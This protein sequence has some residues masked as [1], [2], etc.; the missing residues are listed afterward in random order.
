MAIFHC[1]IGTVSRR[2]GRS[3]VD[4]AAYALHAALKDERT[5]ITH[6]RIVHA[7]APYI[8]TLGTFSPEGTPLDPAYLWS[9]AE[10]A[11]KRKDA[12]TARTIEV[13]LPKELDKKTQDTL[14]ANFA[15]WLRSRYRVAS[16]VGVH[17]QQEHNPH[18]H[19]V[20]TTRRLN[21]DGKLEEKTK[22]LDRKGS[23]QEFKIIRSQWAD[24]CNR[25]LA[26]SGHKARISEKSLTAQGITERKPQTHRGI[27]GH[28]LDL[29]I[30]GMTRKT[31]ANHMAKL[32][33]KEIKE[34]KDEK[35]RSIN[36]SRTLADAYTTGEGSREGADSRRAFCESEHK[37]KKSLG[38]LTELQKV[39]GQPIQN[40]Q[41]QHQNWFY[42]RRDQQLER[43]TE[44]TRQTRRRHTDTLGRSL[45]G[46]QN[47][48]WKRN[49]TTPST[50][51]GLFIAEQIALLKTLAHKP[52][53][54]QQN[55]QI[56]SS[57]PSP[58]AGSPREPRERPAAAPHP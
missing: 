20:I 28:S 36:E 49:S 11:E 44:H 30:L 46:R 10:I 12:R 33:E 32:I 53:K 16:T 17:R 38:R 9:K 23:R 3:A 42:T 41:R 22:E 6:N 18:A 34:T 8:T 2:K 15:A 37:F 39:D 48:R 25:A 26:Q 56:P 40:D 1:H 14:A 7:E 27:K 50:N 51:P 57:P 55:E 5:G 29:K 43:N 31:Y 4:A 13:S 21:A 47:R 35:R 54:R 52:I 24:L 45:S 19:I 58:P